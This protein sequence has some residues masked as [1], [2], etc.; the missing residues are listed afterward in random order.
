M[1]DAL[2]PCLF[3]ISKRGYL[4]ATEGAYS[5]PSSGFIFISD[6]GHVVLQSAATGVQG[7][8]GARV[9]CVSSSTAHWSHSPLGNSSKSARS[10]PRNI[11]LLGL[12]AS[13]WSLYRGGEWIPHWSWAEECKSHF[14]L[15]HELEEWESR[16]P[17]HSLWLSHLCPTWGLTD[18]QLF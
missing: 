6:Y 4:K 1:P 10:L 8:R 2:S 15:K 5:P 3:S 18:I 13:E 11:S 7:Q 17:H 9:W 16:T 12:S 14:P